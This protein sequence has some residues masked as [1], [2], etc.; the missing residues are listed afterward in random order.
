[1][2]Q[3]RHRVKGREKAAFATQSLTQATKVNH[4]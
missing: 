4:P 3:R 2:S 1:M